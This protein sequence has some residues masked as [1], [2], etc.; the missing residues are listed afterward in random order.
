MRTYITLLILLSTAIGTKA[1]DGIRCVQQSVVATIDFG[2]FISYIATH[3]NLAYVYERRV[4]IHA[5]DVSDPANPIP[6]AIMPETDNVYAL[7]ATNGLLFVA[8]NSTGILIY[9]TSDPTNPTLI[10]TIEHTGVLSDVVIDAD[11]LYYLQ[12][13]TLRIADISDPSNPIEIGTYHMGVVTYGMRIAKGHAFI[14]GSQAGLYIIDISDP[15][16][17]TLRHRQDIPG[18]AQDV[19]INGSYVHVISDNGLAPNNGHIRTYDISQPDAPIL[20]DELLVPG[21]P[22]RMENHENNLYIANGHSVQVLDVS[23]ASSPKPLGMLSN[24]SNTGYADIAFTNNHLLAPAG[25]AGLE[26]IDP[27]AYADPVQSK[28]TTPT[29]PQRVSLKDNTLYVANAESGLTIY[30]IQDKANPTLLST[31]NTPGTAFDVAIQQSTAL[32]A[33]ADSGLLLLDVADPSNPQPITT[34]A[35]QGAARA[36]TTYFGLAYIATDL[37]LEIVNFTNPQSPFQVSFLSLPKA[38]HLALGPGVVYVACDDLGLHIVNTLNPATPMPIGYYNENNYN[39][40]NIAVDAN[41]IFVSNYHNDNNGWLEVFDVTNPANPRVTD[42][43]GYGDDGADFSNGLL[44]AIQRNELTILDPNTPHDA[45]H[46]A[47]FPLT[48]RAGFVHVEDETA[49]ITSP[50]A[51]TLTII[52]IAGCACDAD[53]N[54][55]GQLNA[56]DVYAYLAG[57]GTL[58][59]ETDLNTDGQHNFFDIAAFVQSFLAGCP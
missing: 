49:Y 33:D 39:V 7:A 23:S 56:D 21:R 5:F 42:I 41:R 30:D 44:Y 10:S 32:V 12:S 11:R 54:D 24:L 36:I 19:T 40:R 6:L 35:T 38:H 3:D 47:S 57:F 58:S 26:I 25:Y 48:H 46:I 8:R 45:T 20:I 51:D 17:P 28:T 34:Y 55:D 4:G 37:G 9:D 27:H 18:F 50:N 59:P 53:F 14:A 52:S 16:N 43:V 13:G 15:I 22:L 31:L 2:D 1:A 29:S